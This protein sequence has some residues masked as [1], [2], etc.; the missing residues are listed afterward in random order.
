[1][2][3][4]NKYTKWIVGALVLMNLVL[5][6]AFFTSNSRQR[7][8]HSSKKIEKFLQKELNL[9]DEQSVKFKELRNAH[10]QKSKEHWKTIRSLKKEMLEAIS[11]ESPDTLNANNLADQIGTL[12]AKKEKLLINHYL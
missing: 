11:A 5:L 8:E 9:T 10:F 3:F 4:Y 1:M 2:S 7:G 6:F 12:E